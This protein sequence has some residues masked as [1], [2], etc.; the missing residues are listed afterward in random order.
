[1]NHRYLAQ[2]RGNFVVLP[3][4]QAQLFFKSVSDLLQFNGSVAAPSRG[5]AARS[6]GYAAGG[7]CT[8]AA[9]MRRRHTQRTKQ[10]T[11]WT[12]RHVHA[13]MQ[14]KWLL[15]NAGSENGRRDRA[16]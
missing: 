9:T 6:T 10:I 7:A 13:P 4:Q 2:M 12:T 11:T 8:A 3:L 16:G 14:R 5:R 15:N 1:M